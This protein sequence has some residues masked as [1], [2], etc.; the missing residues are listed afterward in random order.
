MIKRLFTYG[1]VYPPLEEG[2]EPMIEEI[3]VEATTREVG[4]RI[5]MMEALEDYEPGWTD[6][7]DLPPGGEFGVV[8]VFST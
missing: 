7:I 6:I 2:G 3:D 1:I 5:A 4:K 8:T